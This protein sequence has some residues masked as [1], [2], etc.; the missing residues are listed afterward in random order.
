[1]QY[2]RELPHF[3]QSLDD[4]V[5]IALVTEKYSMADPHTITTYTLS[6]R[7]LKPLVVLPWMPP[8]VPGE[9]TVLI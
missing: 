4:V 9:Q 3:E 6:F 2:R 7:Q 8:A 1:L 5:D